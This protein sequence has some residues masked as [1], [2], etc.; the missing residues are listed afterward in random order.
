MEIFKKKT[1]SLSC[2]KA[3]KWCIIIASWTVALME[4]HNIRRQSSVYKVGK[5]KLEALCV[6]MWDV[7][8]GFKVSTMKV[9]KSINFLKVLIIWLFDNDIFLPNFI[10]VTPL[11][12][13]ICYSLTNMSE[14]ELCLQYDIVANSKCNLMRGK[15]RCLGTVLY[16]FQL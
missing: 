13:R 10:V 4:K 5:D 12:S 6:L 16:N 11:C 7:L 1:C 9:T 2:R 3:I 14:I 8:M 15:W